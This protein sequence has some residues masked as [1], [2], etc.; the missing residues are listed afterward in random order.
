[1]DLIVGAAFA[2]NQEFDGWKGIIDER[3]GDSSASRKGDGV[4]RAEIGQ[5]A[6]DPQRGLLPL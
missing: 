6:I 3:M 1:V 4:T 2:D 5:T